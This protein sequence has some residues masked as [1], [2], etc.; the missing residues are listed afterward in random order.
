LPR[1]YR[2]CFSLPHSFAGGIRK[3]LA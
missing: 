2:N 3:P 1:L